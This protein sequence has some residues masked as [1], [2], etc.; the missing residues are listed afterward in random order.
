[1]TATSRT[2]YCCRQSHEAGSIEKCSQAESWA[3]LKSQ[4]DRLLEKVRNL[5]L[6]YQGA[7]TCTV[8][9][10]AELNRL[11]RMA[12]AG[13]ELVKWTTILLEVAEPRVEA[14]EAADNAIRNYEEV[15]NG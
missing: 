15:S 9:D 6:A 11:Q 14:L 1:M 8:A 12:E 2:C 13:A 3:N 5:E 10:M 4:R 7:I